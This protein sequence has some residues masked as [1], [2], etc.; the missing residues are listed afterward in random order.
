M[1]THIASVL[2]IPL[3][4]GGLASCGDR[5][6]SDPASDENGEITENVDAGELAAAAKLK[7]AE[8]PVFREIVAFR[9]KSRA[10]YNN[11][12]FDELEKIAT[13]V[14][15]SKA[16]F[17]NGSWKIFQFHDSLACRDEEPEGM[18]QLHDRIHKEW[19]AAKPDSITARVAHADFFVKYAWHARGSGY[20]DTVTPKAWKAF[21][22]RLGKA[23][24]I[25]EGARTLSQKD[26]YFWDVALTVGKGQ[27]WDKP[28]FDAVVAEAV[29][30]EPQYFGYDLTR[31]S[32]LLP[33][34]YGEPGDWEA[35]AQQASERPGGLGAEV[36]ARIVMNLQG[37]HDNV[38]RESKASWP[39]TREGLK[40]MRERY[41]QS[42]EIRSMA[43]RMAV[44]AGDR[45]FAKESFDLLGDTYLPNVW[46]KPERF[47]HFRNWAETGKW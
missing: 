46:R 25:L 33:R 20:A 14:R 10:A 9:G 23:A 11:S 8:D 16:R 39:R 34:W 1:K 40:L 32:T 7:P 13:E 41:P 38:F 24:K 35:Y 43:A 31:A 27:S 44:R 42:L 3:V 22:I 47:T 37:Y 4:F 12:H 30:F 21:G 6:K 2:W 19:I 36:Y 28:A 5:G 17:G 26:P 18:W 29:A 45:E 15:E